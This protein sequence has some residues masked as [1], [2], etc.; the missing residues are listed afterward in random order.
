[1]P[2]GYRL[3][4]GGESAERDS[5][6]SKLM[7]NVG[8][9]LVLLI[10]TVV[11]SFNSFRLSAIVFAVAALAPGLGL[12]CVWAFGYPFGFVV[13]VG[14]MGLVGLAINAAIVI[15]AELKE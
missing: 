3:E 13:I 7:A 1:M 5:A 14:L 8:L 4:F 12:L 6:V 9:I 11:L 15:I 10:T 2:P